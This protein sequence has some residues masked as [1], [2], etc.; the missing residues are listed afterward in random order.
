[1]KRN[2]PSA[3]RP[4]PHSGTCVRR[5]SLGSLHHN[6]RTSRKSASHVTSRN[7][8]VW[9]AASPQAK[10][11]DATSWSAQMYTAFVGASMALQSHA[12]LAEIRDSLLETYASDDAMNQLILSDLDPQAWR[13]QPPGQKGSGRTIAAIFAHLHNVRCK[14]VRLTAPQLKCPPPLDP[15]RCTRKQAA[16]ALRR[17]AAQCLRML[18][19]AL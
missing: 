8:N 10:F 6:S 18:S 16:A 1:M 14:W 11:E 17:S 5:L 19:D 2:F 15:D 7:R 13:A 12:A 3:L 9:S 4:A